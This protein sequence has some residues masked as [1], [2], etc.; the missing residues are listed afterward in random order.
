[1]IAT[2]IARIA[3]PVPR[4]QTFDFLVPAP[5]SV[6]PGVRVRVPFG[7]RRLVGVVIGVG[8]DSE[9]PIARLKPVAD[10]LDLQPV[11]PPKLLATLRWA[12]DYYHHP[13]G[14]VLATALPVPLR[15]G[16]Q[17]EPR[18][19][20]TYCLTEAG[21]AFDTTALGRAAVQ[22]RLLALLRAAPWHRLQPEQCHHV[23]PSWHRAMAALV[24]KRLVAI[25]QAPVPSAAAMP[26]ASPVTLNAAQRAAAQT[27]LAS[28]GGYQSFLLHGIT[29][30][31][32]TE[33][34]LRVVESVIERGQQALVLVPEIAL[35]PQLIERFRQRLDAAVVVLHSGLSVSQRH[36]G[37]GARHAIG[38]IYAVTASRGVH[39]R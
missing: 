23:S 27:I 8:A 9:L 36:Q 38:G 16:S 11:F 25:D 1:M 3:V 12:A 17:V 35:T 39:R 20:Q 30:S 21:L 10:V 14:E 26:P 18:R 6:R 7:A 19:A 29:G 31:G 32:K 15:R 24:E 13:L 28:L 22:Q 37:G 34:Y 5:L 4:R 2:P 33:V